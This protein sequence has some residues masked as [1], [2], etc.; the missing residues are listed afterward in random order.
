MFYNINESAVEDLTGKGL[1][2]LRAGIIRTPLLPM[3]TFLDGKC[4]GQEAGRALTTGFDGGPASG[5]HSHAPAPTGD[6]LR[7]WAHT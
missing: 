3:E 4:A 7:R 6:V 5:H 1:E 2:D